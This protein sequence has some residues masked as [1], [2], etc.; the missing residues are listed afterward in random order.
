MKNSDDTS[1]IRHFLN[2][3]V[4]TVINILLGLISTPLITRVASPDEYGLFS[5]FNVYSDLA[6]AILFIGLDRGIVRFFYNKDEIND[7]RSLL[8]LCFVVPMLSGFIVGIIFLLLTVTG[9]L[10]TQFDIYLS[11]LLCAYI[12]FNIW[13]RLSYL[14]LKL[15][16]K[17]KEYSLCTVIQKAVYVL[18]VV[19]Y[20]LGIKGYYLQMMIMSSLLSIFVAGLVATVIGKNYWHFSKVKLPCN[21]L[22]IFKYSAP[23]IIY[24][25]MDSLMDSM[26]KISINS[27]LSEYDV[28]IYSSGAALVA[29][30]SIFKTIF[31]TV[32][33]PMQTE[34]YVK[35]P[36]DKTFIQR[37]NRYITIIM[38]FVGTNVLFFKDLICYILGSEYREAYIVIPFLFLGSVIYAISDTTITGIDYSKKSYYHSII[39]FVAFVINF[40]GNT[41]LVQLMG[42]KGAALATCLSFLTYLILRIIISN[43]YYYVD[44]GL[45]KMSLSLL[46]LTIF[47]SELTFINNSVINII[48]YLVLMALIIVLYR[49]DIA[50]LID[51]ILGYLGLKKNNSI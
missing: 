22:E 38:L 24:T 8:K 51:Y 29:I 20:A 49:K 27:Y 21:Q 4:G 42:I 37:G 11:I 30:F 2:V 47:A 13:N 7:Q 41:I 44:Y 3:G 26:D 43:R 17:S 34:H 36:E 31:D 48:I 39:G 50:S 6:I 16:Y 33:I 19:I 10:E 46:L 1:F 23:F 25:L 28:G 14:I 9:V 18:I 32:W 45:K 40:V 15:T 5:I 35:N 12:L